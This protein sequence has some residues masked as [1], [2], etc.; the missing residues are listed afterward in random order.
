ME[1][2]FELFTEREIESVTMKEIADAS[3]VGRA[4]L[5][6]YF[7]SKLDLVIAISSWKWKEYIERTVK[8]ANQL[9]L[10]KMTG[11]E[12]LSKYLDAFLELYR[13]YRSTLRFNYRFNSYLRNERVTPEQLEPYMQLVNKLGASFHVFYERGMKDGTLNANIPEKEMFLGSFHIMLAAAT[14]YAV[15]LVYIPENYDPEKELVM[16]KRLLFLEYTKGTGNETV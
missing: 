6:N 4:T 2:G 8:A 16:L 10:E 14:R 13:N 12:F 5:F 15:G 11:A 7:N 1:K 3:L 9:D